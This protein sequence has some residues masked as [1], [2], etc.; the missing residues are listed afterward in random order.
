MNSAPM[1]QKVH[2]PSW[3]ED[4]EKARH[5]SDAQRPGFQL[6]LTWFEN[7]RIGQQ[8]QPGREAARVF[9]VRQVKSKPRAEWQL[10]QWAEALR[11]YLQWL[12]F[13][14]QSGAEVLTLEE[15]VYQAMERVGGRRGLALR[16]RQTYGRWAMR[17]ARW[18]GEARA[19][20][21]Q[22]RIANDRHRQ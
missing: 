10:T 17:Y 18:V 11:W 4:L 7:W 3:R 22:E 8:L 2:S 9:W 1:S 16:T 6:V 19:M 5:V 14:Q 12:K 13:A 21:K 15:R 20:L